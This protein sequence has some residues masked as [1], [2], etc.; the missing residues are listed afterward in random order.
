M[1][2]NKKLTK[3]A[4]V[5]LDVEDWYHLDYIS[6][7]KKTTHVSMLD[8]LEKI[9][10]ILNKRKC[11]ATLF[12]VGELIKV[13]KE[14]IIYYE[15]E[16]FEIA[17]HG[18]SHQRP[19]TLSISDFKKEIIKTKKN[20]EQITKKEVIGFRAPCFSLDRKRLDI[21]FNSGYSYDSSKIDFKVHNLYGNLDLHNF[22]QK[23]HNI[24]FNKDNKFEFELPTF[25]F[26]NQNI[27][28]SGGGYLRIFTE[29]IIKKIIIQKEKKNEPI[30]FYIHP[31]EFS[32]INIKISK[33]GFKN[34]LLCSQMFLIFQYLLP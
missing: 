29:A 22:N 13:L 14:K 6:N 33:I 28:F 2:F 26:L 30:F 15:D 18:Y 27:P 17:S 11:K 23:C 4:V 34:Y 19:L 7:K 9:I 16:G 5:G 12:V 31:F 8:G 1:N 32:K 24:F 25:R 10:Q 20:L 3:I 21:L